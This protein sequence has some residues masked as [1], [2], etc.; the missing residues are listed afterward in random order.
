MRLYCC[1]FLIFLAS[2]VN[3]QT[4]NLKDKNISRQTKREVEILKTKLFKLPEIM[5]LNQELKQYKEKV[6]MLPPPI[7]M[8][9]SPYYEFSVGYDTPTEFKIK[10][11]IRIEK[12]FINQTNIEPY[13]EIL[14][15]AEAGY[16]SLLQYRQKAANSGL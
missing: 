10:F 7:P 3:A 13:V 4:E 8:P 6:A 12:K 9:E 2:V 16:I 15:K 5:Q 1:F 11:F 14:Y